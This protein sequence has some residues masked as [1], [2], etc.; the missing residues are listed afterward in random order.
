MSDAFR[1]LNGLNQAD[2][3][4]PLP[5]F[6]LC[7]K[8]AARKVRENQEGLEMNGTHHVLVYADDVNIPGG[9]KN[10]IKK[11]RET[12]LQATSDVGLE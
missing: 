5:F 12:L 8:D 10:T 7:V 2:A 11:N 3:L 4:R 9:N 1:I 6:Q